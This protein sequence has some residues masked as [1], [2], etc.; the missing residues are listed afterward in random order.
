MVN[1]S[2]LYGSNFGLQDVSLD[3]GLS[4]TAGAVLL[5]WVGARPTVARY[6]RELVPR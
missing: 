1:L 6:L 3:D 2:G 5:D 4:L